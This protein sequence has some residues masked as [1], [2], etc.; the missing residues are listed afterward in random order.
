MRF[1]D[2]TA[3]NHFHLN[4]LWHLSLLFLFL[5]PMPVGSYFIILLNYTQNCDSLVSLSFFYIYLLN[6][7]GINSLN[8][9]ENAL[10]K[11]ARK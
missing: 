8:H 1:I 7:D 10:S 11:D 4:S 9:H 2:H 5:L 6:D 3:S